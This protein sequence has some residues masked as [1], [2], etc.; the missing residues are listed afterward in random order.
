MTSRRKWMIGA[1]V[2]GALVLWWILA[3]PPA[4]IVETAT[5]ARETL[6]VT[7]AEDGVTRSRERYTVAAPVTG[8]LSRLVLREGAAVEQGDVIASIAPPAPDPALAAFYRAELTAA[9]ARRAESEAALQEAVRA[10]D[11]AVRELERRRPLFDAGALTRETIERFEA[12][13]TAAAAAVERAQ[14]MHEGAEAAVQASRSRL[15]GAEPTTGERTPVELVRAPT[16]GVVLRVFEE[17]ERPIQAGS[18]IVEIGAED[19]LEVVVDVLT[20]EA[21]GIQPGQTVRITE[22]GGS[23]VLTGVVGQVEPAAFTRISALGVEEQRVNVLVA[24]PS[25]PAGLGSGYRVEAEV[26]TWTGSDV[27]SVP[28]AALFQEG[29]GWAAF[30]IA[31]GRAR[32]RPVEIG[33]QGGDRVEVVAGLDEGEQ[34]VVFPSD[35]VREGTRVTLEVAELDAR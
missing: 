17:S 32:L 31:E 22:W 18:P 26:V 4:V 25:V 3:P 12:A 34:V 16:R 29:D 1:V 27:L 30:V 19:G 6:E 28:A 10:H 11:Q 35:Q 21:V 9:E 14:A 24:L 7:V 20:E 5:V 8:Q 33:R 13:A 23:E 2:V 15:F